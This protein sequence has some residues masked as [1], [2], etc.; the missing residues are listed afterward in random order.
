VSPPNHW[1]LLEIEPSVRDHHFADDKEV[2]LA[3]IAISLK[4]IADVAVELLTR[5]GGTP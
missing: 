1:P 2:F 3:S 4:R 5:T